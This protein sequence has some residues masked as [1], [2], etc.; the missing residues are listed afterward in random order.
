LLAFV[1]VTGPSCYETE[2]TVTA[3]FDGQP[4]ETSHPG[5]IEFTQ[6]RLYECAENYQ[7]A[8]SDVWVLRTTRCC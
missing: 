8:P 3:E 2:A 7:E 6:A 1:K 5:K 4:I